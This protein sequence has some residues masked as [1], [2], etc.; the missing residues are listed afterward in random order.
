MEYR[1]LG[2]TGLEV[3]AL[4][5]GGSALGGVYGHVDTAAAIRTV[6][7][8]LD[9]GLN[10]IDTAPFYGLTRAEEVLGQAL[11][12]AGRERALVATK[13]GRYG[14]DAFDFSAARVTRSID[15]SLRRLQ[16]DYVDLVQAHDIE[17]TSLDRVIDETIPALER[18]VR[19]GKARYFG[20]TGLPL[21]IFEIVLSYAQV[22]TVLSYARYTLNNNSIVRILPFLRQRGVGVISASPFSLGLLT[23]KGPPDWHLAPPELKTA[24]RQAAD[25]CAGR[26]VNISKL[27]LQ[28]SLANPDIHTVLAGTA[29]EEELRRNVQWAGEPPDEDLL[30]ELLAFFAPY[31]DTLWP[32]GLPEN[33]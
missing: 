18:V 14:V 2:R 23:H 24:C 10:F 12:E 28:Y 16:T 11:R 1:T 27:A 8:A 21:R 29:I 31:R 32:A 19:E 6:H 4:S 7:T 25:W 26:G 5:L 3:S 30:R 33:N 20:I 17:F 13:V 9:L 22:D 15:E